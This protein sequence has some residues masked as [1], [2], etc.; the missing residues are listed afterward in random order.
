MA[1][2]WAEEC[3]ILHISRHWKGC[4]L[5]KWVCCVMAISEGYRN[6]EL[7]VNNF[8]VYVSLNHVHDMYECS[9]ISLATGS[10]TAMEHLFL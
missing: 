9:M 7:C 5:D 6:V 1:V 10:G 2:I 8:Q 4:M 3:P